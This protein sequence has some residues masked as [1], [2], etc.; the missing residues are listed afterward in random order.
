MASNEGV[1]KRSR[2]SD[3]TLW[4]ALVAYEPGELSASLRFVER[5]A[6]ENG[7]SRAFADAAVAEY[8]RF[9]FLAMRAGHSVT[10][11][12]AVDQVWHLHLTYTRD[13]WQRFCGELLGTP[14]HHGPTR[15]GA[16]EGARFQEDYAR[17]LEAYVEW[18]SEDP[19][20]TLWPSAHERFRDPGRFMRIDRSGYWLLP[21]P[22]RW[23]AW[24]ASLAIVGVTTS[25]QALPL[26]PFDWT[27][28]P[29]LRLEVFLLVATTLLAMVWRRHLRGDGV[30][31]S[32]TPSPAEAAH[33]AGGPERV[34]DQA[35]TALLVAGDLTLTPQGLQS[36]RMPN[37]DDP[38]PERSI[39][40]AARLPVSVPKLIR[41]CVHHARSVEG[42]M[43][44]RGWLV[45]AERVLA[46][47]LWPALLPA[48]ATAF[49]AIKI[50]VG[51]A[52]DKPVG[53]LVLLVILGTI[54][55]LVFLLRAVR[56]S[57]A[58]DAVLKQLR[59]RH[60]VL[61]RAASRPNLALG[62]ALFGTSVLATSALADYH[63]RRQPDSS[64]SGDGGS[65]SGG[66]GGSGDSGCGGCGGGGD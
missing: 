14:L 43:H 62:V 55:T 65:S 11:S 53:Y 48:A 1:P 31:A 33:L 59:A 22:A 20:I 2:A 60:G 58:G 40:L 49:G 5:L 32:G 46:V 38:E 23:R 41:Q 61:Q 45:P 30:E 39:L 42:A 26:N 18:F 37:A 13:Y 34:I 25:A 35:V 44:R 47:R 63:T 57:R 28:P 27:A 4:C 10:P 64:A 3:D 19:P 52:R 15:G 51:V 54:I 8:R 50:A 16:A 12:D 21:R 66:D 36:S 17:T 56:A 7:W 29:F 24:L 9:V 6:R